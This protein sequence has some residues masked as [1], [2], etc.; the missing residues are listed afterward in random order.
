MRVFVY[1]LVALGV[2]LGCT[3]HPTYTNEDIA[4][5][6]RGVAQMGRYEYTDAEKT[7]AELVARAPGWLDARVNHAIAT[8]NRQAEGD[9]QLALAILARVLDED[10]GHLRAL[11]TSG[12]LYLYLGE[13]SIAVERLQQVT[14]GDPQDAYAAYFLGQ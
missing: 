7:F 12:I 1:L 6:D 4:L 3:E 2:G 5:N 8:L 14:I 10:R 9:E 13:A 11:Y